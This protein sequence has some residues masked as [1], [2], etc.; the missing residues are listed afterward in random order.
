M[1]LEVSL[2]LLIS[3]MSLSDSNTEPI[4][5]TA[6]SPEASPDDA[7]SM[8]SAMSQALS[9]VANWPTI[10]GSEVDPYLATGLDPELVVPPF[11]MVNLR[12]RSDFQMG[13]DPDVV[14]AAARAG[15]MGASQ[16]RV[17]TLNPA[18]YEGLARTLRQSADDMLSIPM[19]P[20][21]APVEPVDFSVMT[22][23]EILEVPVQY[24]VHVV[25][26]AA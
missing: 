4:P 26:T 6:S 3:K 11:P 24:L 15:R 16:A 20:N 5:L 13:I 19:S 21:V 17:G 25:R 12:P 7:L 8:M 23:D 9:D 18:R 1:I 2:V 14:P 22:D 10:D